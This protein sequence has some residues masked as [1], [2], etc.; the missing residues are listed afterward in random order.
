MHDKLASAKPRMWRP[1]STDNEPSIVALL[2]FGRVGRIMDGQCFVH[3]GWWRG[4]GSP[5]SSDGYHAT[6]AQ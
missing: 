5:F 6:P 2:P 4:A 3:P 1:G